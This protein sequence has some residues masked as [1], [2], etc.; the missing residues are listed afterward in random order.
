MIIAQHES[1]ITL[2]Q[3]LPFRLNHEEITHKS[4]K[5]TTTPRQKVYRGTAL[6][7]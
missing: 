4:S 2:I 3:A 7:S 1:P 6:G 5:H